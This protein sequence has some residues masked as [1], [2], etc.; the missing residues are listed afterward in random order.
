MGFQSLPSEDGI[1]RNPARTLNGAG[2]FQKPKEVF[3]RLEPLDLRRNCL[4]VS[5]DGRDR[6]R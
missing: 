6:Y 3:S 1:F 2:L 4:F 5:G